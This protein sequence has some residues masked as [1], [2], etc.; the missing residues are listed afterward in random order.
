[1]DLKPFR[2]FPSFQEYLAE[3]WGF[4]KNADNTEQVT[5]GLVPTEDVRVKTKTSIADRPE[6][7]AAIHIKAAQED[8]RG[9]QDG[10]GESL[11]RLINSMYISRRRTWSRSW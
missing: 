7:E 10:G 4:D 11:I 3:C 2:G 6:V 9:D 5:D 1:M 8:V